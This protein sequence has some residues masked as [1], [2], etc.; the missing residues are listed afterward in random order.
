MSASIRGESRFA[1]LPCAF[2]RLTGCNLRCV[3]C[4]TPQA[5]YGGTRMTRKDVLD[6][7]LAL[8]TPLVE[9][10]AREPL[11]QPGVLP[12]LRE[13]CYPGKPLLLETSVQAPVDDVDNPV[14]KL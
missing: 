10:T 14:H 2:V 8:G 9:L 12:L 3:W 4:D 5:F 1:G 7:A 11:L 13:L 6:R